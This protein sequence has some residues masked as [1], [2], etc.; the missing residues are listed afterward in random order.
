MENNKQ[1][2]VISSFKDEHFFLSNFYGRKVTYRG[3]TYCNTEAAFQAQK[4]KDEN[5]RK[6]F[7][8]CNPSVAKQLGRRVKLR[9]DWEA[10]KEEEMYFIVLA[11]FMQHPS[12]QEKLIATFPAKLVEGNDW[13]DTCWGVCRGKGENRLG[14]I[15]MDIRDQLVSLYSR[16]GAYN[17]RHPEPEAK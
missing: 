7:T 5:E 6:L 3:L 2:E 14:K 10:V 9:S 13:K 4:T 1:P 11:K 17:A 12:L 15:L 16:H 8:A